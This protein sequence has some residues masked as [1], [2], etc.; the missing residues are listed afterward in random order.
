[1]SRVM[2]VACVLG[3][4]GVPIAISDT[5]A[6]SSGIP[7]TTNPTLTTFEVSGVLSYKNGTC[8]GGQFHLSSD[9]GTCTGAPADTARD[10]VLCGQPF[11]RLGSSVCTMTLIGSAPFGVGLFAGFDWDS[12][13]FID[14][15][16]TVVGPM[17]SGSYYTIVNQDPQV[18]PPRS[19]RV[20][21]LPT[22]LDN[23]DTDASVR[24]L[25]GCSVL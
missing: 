15:G 10:G 18:T 11:N 8:T 23:T 12:S 1:M 24:A 17:A 22:N 5:D 4:I 25:V 19:S 21:A 2:F 6:C 16:E 14:H 20:L 9:V 13:G 7:M 3:V